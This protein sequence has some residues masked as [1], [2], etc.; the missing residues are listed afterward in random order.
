MMG[1]WTH[2][3]IQ[4]KEMSA[5]SRLDEC[6]A[7][8]SRKLKNDIDVLSARINQ[9][10]KLDEVTKTFSITEVK[11]KSITPFTYLPD[12]TRSASV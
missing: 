11:T 5:N 4:S 7:I 12:F 8:S 6:K 3:S 1:S 2:D 9:P 10:I